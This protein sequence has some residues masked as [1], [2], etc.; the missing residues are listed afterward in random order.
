MLPD[1]GDGIGY[2]NFKLETKAARELMKCMAASGDGKSFA[3]AYHA[4]TFEEEKLLV[5][6]YFHVDVT[7]GTLKKEDAKVYSIVSVQIPDGPKTDIY[8]RLDPRM[9]D[10][11][12][13]A[14]EKEK[15]G[16]AKA[17]QP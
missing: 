5:E 3:T 12:K 4:I 9:V 6:Q 1:F 11:I 8:F 17:V 13:V 15:S 7:E 14:A 10:G 2:I 16:K